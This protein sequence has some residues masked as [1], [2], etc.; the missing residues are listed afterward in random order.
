[1]LQVFSTSWALFLGMFMLMIGNGVQGTLLG[2]RGAEEGFSTF[3]LSIVMSAYFAGF[4]FSSKAT[5]S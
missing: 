5:L 2:L 3:S 1:M 4:L